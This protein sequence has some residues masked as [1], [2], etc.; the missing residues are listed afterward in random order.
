MPAPLQ[1]LTE[2]GHVIGARPYE[3]LDEQGKRKHGR[4]KREEEN[5]WL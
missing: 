3:I 4:N 5:K 1:A 2:Y